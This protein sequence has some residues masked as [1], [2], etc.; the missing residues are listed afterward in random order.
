MFKLQCCG[1]VGFMIGLGL[2]FKDPY[3]GFGLKV[4]L[5]SSGEAIPKH[6]TQNVVSPLNSETVTLN[7]ETLNP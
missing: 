3:Q 4:S 6:S 5:F 7:P 2:K 1:L